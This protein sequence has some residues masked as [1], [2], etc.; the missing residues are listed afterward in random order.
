MIVKVTAGQS[1]ADVALQHCGSVDYVF[2]IAGL[3]SAV[4]NMSIDYVAQGEMELLV[5]EVENLTKKKLRQKGV[6]ICTGRD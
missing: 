4:P 5:P 2:E 6:I 3:N 1:I